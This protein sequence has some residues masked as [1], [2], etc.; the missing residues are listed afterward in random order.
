MPEFYIIL[1]LKII[2]M[3]EH[4]RCQP[5]IGVPFLS[6]LPLSFSLPLPPTF[7]FLRSRALFTFLRFYMVYEG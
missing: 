2:K 1:A 4:G 6:P 5:T 7:P 3:P